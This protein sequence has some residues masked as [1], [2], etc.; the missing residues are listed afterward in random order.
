MRSLVFD[1]DVNPARGD[2]D[3]IIQPVELKGAAPQ[4]LPGEQRKDTPSVATAHRV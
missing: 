1:Y 4:E 2:I 3:H